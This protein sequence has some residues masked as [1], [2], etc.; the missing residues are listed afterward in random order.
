MEPQSLLLFLLI[1]LAAGWL[2][3][4]IMKGGG[5]GLIGNMVVGVIGAVLGGWLFGLFG[6]ALGGLF[7]SLVTAVVGAVVLLYLIKLIKRA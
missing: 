2:A 7:G 3:G 6:I 1:G 5:F 4:R